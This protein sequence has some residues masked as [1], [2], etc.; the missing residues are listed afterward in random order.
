MPW[1]WQLPNWPKFQWDFQ[2]V[3]HLEKQ[4]LLGVGSSFAFLKNINKQDYNRFLVE[5]LS[6]EGLESS[7]KVKRQ[8]R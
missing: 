1:N 5:I 4:F 2:S 6:S 7:R 8:K 3:E